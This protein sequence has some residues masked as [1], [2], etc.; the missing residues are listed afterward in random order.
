MVVA[1]RSAPVYG[2]GFEIHRPFLGLVIRRIAEFAL[3]PIASILPSLPRVKIVDVGAA[4]SP[5]APVYAKLL[6]TLPC[7]IV[8]FEPWADANEQLNRRS[9]ASHLYL[10]Y[11]IG[12]GTQRTFYECRSPYCSSLFEP[13]RA[14]ADRFQNLGEL[15]TV[16]GTRDI[17]TKRLDD[18]AE[19]FGTDFLKV[20]VQGAELLVLEGA[21]Q[22]LRATLAVHIEVEFVPLY[23]D[24]PLFADVD[25]FL[26]EQGF[27]FHTLIPSG[28]TFK[29][30]VVNNNPNGWARQILWAD[31]VYVRDFMKFAEMQPP[32]LLKLAAILHE[33]YES[34]D[35]AALALEAYDRLTG[36][37]LQ[38]IYLK[39]LSAA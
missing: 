2:R 19:T 38:K 9:E 21:V 3:F 33:V 8:G 35:L 34:I 15:L 23:K 27:V 6:E 20:D 4:E 12:D 1:N 14:L 31:A 26:R 11:A 7:E 37:G 17:E 25:S 24:Q 29:P 16:G 13:N 32:E 22:R 18:L 28:R 10:P 5:E 39:R 30:V 36:S